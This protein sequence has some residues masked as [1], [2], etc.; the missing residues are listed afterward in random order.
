[1][2]PFIALKS[3]PYVN[4]KQKKHRHNRPPIRLT[5]GWS[6]TMPANVAAKQHFFL[7]LGKNKDEFRRRLSNLFSLFGFGRASS[8]KDWWYSWPTK[9]QFHQRKW[10]EISIWA[11][12]SCWG[13]S[14]NLRVINCAKVEPIQKKHHLSTTHHTSTRKTLTIS[15]WNKLL[16]KNNM[17]MGFGID[18]PQKTRK[19]LFAS[20]HPK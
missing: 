2:F 7:T 14:S 15:Q 13:S 10:K 17:K 1:M 8:A 6:P 5:S 3:Q 16:Q 20:T 4:H 11:L 18:F 19:P 12:K 9:W